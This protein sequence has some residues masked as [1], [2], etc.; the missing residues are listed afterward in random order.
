MKTKKSILFIAVIH[1][2]LISCIN[3]DDNNELNQIEFTTIGQGNLYGNG[4]ENIVEQNLVVSNENDWN[5]LINKMNS[6]NNVSNGFTKS[7]IDFS[8]FTV[9]AVFDEIKTSGGH[10]IDMIKIVEN[11]TEIIVTIDHILPGIATTIMTQP[12][13]IVKI[14][15]NNKTI[16]F[17]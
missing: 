4:R 17:E 8:N 2:L 10:S 5:E 11:D 15:K 12:Y 14:S 9:L 13:H 1:I 7:N 6:V 3:K 16:I